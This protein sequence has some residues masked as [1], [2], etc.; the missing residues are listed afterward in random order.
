M[1]NNRAIGWNL[2]KAKPGVFTIDWLSWDC[3]KKVSGVGRAEIRI[4]DP[5]HIS[6]RLQDNPE[7]GLIAQEI[8]LK[9][10]TLVLP[11]QFKQESDSA[12]NSQNAK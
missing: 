10:N 1:C 6:L 7:T 9:A 4:T 8:R 11:G 2:R 5:D 12:M 3:L